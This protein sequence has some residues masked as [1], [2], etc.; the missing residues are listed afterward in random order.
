MGGRTREVRGNPRIR[1]VLEAGEG[2]KEQLPGRW[3]S[4]IR[5][6]GSRVWYW[7]FRVE[8]AGNLGRVL[9]G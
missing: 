5:A 7:G 4:K 3:C 2:L 6:V 8:A 1:R 9:G